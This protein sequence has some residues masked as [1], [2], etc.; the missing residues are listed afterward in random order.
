[1]D[2]SI[3][4]STMK[5][6]WAVVLGAIAPMLDSTMI[7]I[8]I[9]ALTKEFSTSLAV[10][11]WIVTGYVLALAL[12]MPLSSWFVNRW[13]GKRVFIWTVLAFGLI[14]VLTGCSWSIQSL[15]IFRLFQGFI[16][17]ILTPLTSTL[18]VKI[19]GPKNIGKV[20]SIVTTPMILGPILGPVI[21][22]FIVQFMSWRWLFF[23]NV[24]V[25]II[26]IPILQKALP[27]F[28]PFNPD[29]RLDVTGTML[30]SFM[31][32]SF[33]YGMTILTE[34]H[35]L[36][37]A[38]VWLILAIVCLFIYM[39]YNHFR[40]NQ[41]IFPLK[42]FSNPNFAAS[43]VGLLFANMGIMGPMMIFPL[44]FQ[45]IRHFSAISAALILIPQG[46]GMLIMRPYIGK[47]MARVGERMTIFTSLFLLFFSTLPLLFITA[48]TSLIWLTVLLFLRGISVGG[49]TIP[50]TSS[51][52]QGLADHE[53]PIAS[54][55]TNMIENIGSSLGSSIITTAVAS[56]SVKHAIISTVLKGYHI[57]FLMT[58]ILFILTSLPLK[59]L[60]NSS[61]D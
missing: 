31:S 23:L 49:V 55:G 35:R 44:F 61:V 21:G 34:P 19:A 20:I 28:K 52:Y 39:Y 56:F 25:V 12:A 29:S 38:S 60:T 26:A 47:I 16:A 24:L 18:L 11:Q 6:A 15:V 41:T 17:G 58:L 36:R 4:K 5:A 53:I 42:L 45:N 7:N 14:S 8:A 32:I 1:M 37:T 22:G 48:Q 2:K 10:A 46:L 40:K 9:N 3:P 30:L 50:L 54:V 27:D 43:S 57:G 51:A 59:W 33:T 13:N